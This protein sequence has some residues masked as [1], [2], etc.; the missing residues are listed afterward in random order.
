MKTSII[1]ILLLIAGTFLS[2][3][4]GLLG[5]AYGDDLAK[6]QKILIE[7]GFKPENSFDN[8]HS[9]KSKTHKTIHAVDL[10]L[11]HDNK[12]AGWT[13]MFMPSLDATVVGDLIDTAEKLHGPGMPFTEQNMIA[14]QL[15]EQKSLL[16]GFDPVS[17]QLSVAVYFDDA[18]AE[19]FD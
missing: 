19:L 18:K 13:L 5:I 6:C 9:Y 14:W 17:E 4:T 15:D 2:A 11:T 1:L 10:V 7:Q 8:L 12:I 16:F 3:Q